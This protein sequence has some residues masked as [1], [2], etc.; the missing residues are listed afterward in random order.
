M[1]DERL[2]ELLND[3]KAE[4]LEGIE[5]LYSTY[6]PGDERYVRKLAA[7]YNLKLS[8]GSDFHGSNKPHIRL[9]SGMGHL[10]IPYERCM[11]GGQLTHDSDTIPTNQYIVCSE[12]FIQINRVH[13]IHS[14]FHFVI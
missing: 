12:T 10:S 8:G 13:N 7:E 1:S 6:Q 11:R 9:G 4:G 3:C 14:I 5:A 2:R